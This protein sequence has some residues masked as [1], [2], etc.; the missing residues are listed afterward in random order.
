MERL[1]ISKLRTEP[2][3]DAM[4]IDATSPTNSI[5]VAMQ[6]HSVFAF[7]EALYARVLGCL[8]YFPGLS[9]SSWL[10]CLY[11]TGLLSYGAREEA[12][13]PRLSTI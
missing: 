5:V 8:G 9:S 3:T 4:N 10:G 2:S 7:P 12:V 1:N 13:D 6:G 11:A